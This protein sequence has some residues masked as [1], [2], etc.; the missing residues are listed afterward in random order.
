MSD[1]VLSLWVLERLEGGGSFPRICSKC[2]VSPSFLLEAKRVR[3]NSQQA[4]KKDSASQ[5]SN[6]K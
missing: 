3:N 4:M 6:G 1:D 5:Q 2:T